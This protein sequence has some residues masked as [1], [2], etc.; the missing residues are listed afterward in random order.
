ML[1]ASTYDGMVGHDDVH[2]LPPNRGPGRASTKSV[3]NVSVGTMKSQP[4]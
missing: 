4:P 2:D 3:R 1:G